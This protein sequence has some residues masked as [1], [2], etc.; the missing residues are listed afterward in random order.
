VIDYLQ[1]ALALLRKELSAH[2]S[3]VPAVRATDARLRH[4]A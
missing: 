4:A 2:G 1:D 3:F